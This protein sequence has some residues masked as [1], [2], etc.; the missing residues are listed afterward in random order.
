WTTRESGGTDSVLWARVAADFD[1]NSA[2]IHVSKAFTSEG[3]EA[4]VFIHIGGDIGQAFFLAGRN[5]KPEYSSY[6]SNAPTGSKPPN[7]YK[8]NIVSATRFNGNGA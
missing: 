4:G 1:R 5:S 8:A 6:Y 7:P 3:D 2:P